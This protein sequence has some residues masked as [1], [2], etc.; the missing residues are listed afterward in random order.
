M[1][2]QAVSPIF[3]DLLE[4]ILELFVVEGLT[5]GK[6]VAEIL[7]DRLNGLNIA[8]LAVDQQLV[9]ACTDVHV[10]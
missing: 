7:Q 3:S 5:F 6:E 8:W 2:F 10:Q 9:A 4:R 1:V